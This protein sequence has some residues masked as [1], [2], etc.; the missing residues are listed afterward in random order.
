MV[1]LAWRLLS[2]VR[3]WVRKEPASTTVGWMPRG[4]NSARSAS[5]GGVRG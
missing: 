4:A 3:N 1:S 5:E 2:V